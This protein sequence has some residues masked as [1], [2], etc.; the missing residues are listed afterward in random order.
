LESSGR[1][2]IRGD[3]NMDETMEGIIKIRRN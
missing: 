1:R 3:R 2:K